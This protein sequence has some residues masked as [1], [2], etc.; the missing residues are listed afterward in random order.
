MSPRTRRRVE[1]GFKSLRDLLVCGLGA[2]SFWFNTTRVAHPDP[3]VLAF[4][5]LLMAAP[6][7]A[8]LYRTVN[9]L[10]APRRPPD[11]EEP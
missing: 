4:S 7:L 3:W 6:S 5:V 8:A 9:A 11:E 1:T 2:W 10:Y